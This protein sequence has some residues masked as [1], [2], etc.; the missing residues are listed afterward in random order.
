MSPLHV[1]QEHTGML[2]IPCLPFCTLCSRSTP[3]PMPILCRGLGN[4]MIDNNIGSY[5]CQEKVNCTSC[6]G[7]PADHRGGWEGILCLC[8]A[9]PNRTGCRIQGW[10]MCWSIRC[11]RGRGKQ[12]SSAG[13]LLL[14]V[15]RGAILGPCCGWGN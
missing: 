9:F 14:G 12:G 10:T 4:F 13:T 7:A 1:H 2:Q 8:S 5:S 6:L 3:P 15:F 11:C